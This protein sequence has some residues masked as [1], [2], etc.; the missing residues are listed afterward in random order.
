VDAEGTFAVVGPAF[1]AFALILA[2]IGGVVLTSPVFSSNTIPPMVKMGMVGV[3]S[4][5]V[6]LRIG[7][8]PAVGQLRDL[9]LAGA[10]VTELV[11]GAV[12][13]LA[14]SALFACVHLGGQLMG[15]QMGFAI[16][17]VID[18]TTAQQV[19]VV[20]QILNILAL[21]VFLA[22]DGHVMMLRAL[23]ESFHTLPLG[24]GEPNQA[25]ILSELV[26]MGA[27]LFEYGLR[28]ALPITCVVLLVNVGLAT[29]A[30]TVPQVNVFM[31]GFIISIGLGLF[32]LIMS[33]PSAV[34]FLKV[35]V[36]EGV[37]GAVRLTRAL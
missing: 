17:N 33:L 10:V 26:R 9:A 36:R 3:L 24:G 20:G 12:M 6:L 29:I 1:I 34:E 19:G 35:V 30:R 15:T 22:F 18:P 16:V 27:K 7:P 5:L 4:L 25:I 23:F 31:F 28:L 21:F 32:V 37:E 8:V 13:G 2:R 14:V 11:A